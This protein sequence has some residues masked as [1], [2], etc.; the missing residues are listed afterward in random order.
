VPTNVVRLAQAILSA[1][2]EEADSNVT[3]DS[4]TI[5]TLGIRADSDAANHVP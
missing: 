1:A 3:N 4:V 5:V 2:H